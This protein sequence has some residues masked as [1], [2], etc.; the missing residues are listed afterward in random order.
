[1]KFTLVDKFNE[2]DENVTTF[3]WQPEEPI[4]WSAGQYLKYTLPHDN[5]DDRGTFR[6]FTIAAPP[7]ELRPRITTRF[8]EKSSTFK[9]KLHSLK[10]GDTIEASKPMGDFALDTTRPAVMVAGGIGITPFRAMI[11]QQNHE[12]AKLQAHL[13]YAN[14]SDNFVFRDQFETVT[15]NQPAFEISY[16]FDPK[17]VELEDIQQAAAKYSDPIYYLS[18]P[19]PMVDNYKTMLTGAGINEDNIKLDD[20]P[21]YDWPLH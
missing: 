7:Y 1:M 21:G 18:G 19:E 3:V 13:L 11:L 17:H 9:T 8:T 15:A 12:G 14:R 4:T 20:F 10:T 5:P 6:W 2:A 16:I